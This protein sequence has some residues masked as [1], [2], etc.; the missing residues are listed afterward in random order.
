MSGLFTSK[1]V[2]NYRFKNRIIM[3]PMASEKATPT[4]EVTDKTINYYYERAKEGL[5]GVIVEH[6]F[7][8]EAGRFSK[9]Q[10]SIAEDSMIDGLSSLASAIK[11]TGTVAIIQLSHAGCEAYHRCKPF[12]P[13]GIS[14]PGKEE[15]NSK[16][17]SIGEISEI[18]T[19]FIKAAE[20]AMKAGFDG[21]E[22]H[23]AH[24]YLLNQFNSPL[25]NHRQDKY[26]G[27]RENRARLSF[28]I[29][30][31]I[32]EVVQDKLLLY[33]LGAVDQFEK[34]LTT[35]DAIWI[36]KELVR[37]GV[38]II[39]ISGGLGGYR[40]SKNTEGYFVTVAKEIN[41]NLTKPVIVAGGITSPEYANKVVEE[42]KIDFVGIGRA[43]LSRPDWPLSA[44]KELT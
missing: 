3:P 18:K 7:I 20:R 5:G 28:E 33:R 10:L 39:D 30:Q 40:G 12:S 24:G 11:S 27:S 41:Q 6:A 13:S 43:I 37:L 2:R 36:A 42:E 38:D 26:G 32:R 22:I 9:R 44:K 23:G 1:K 16:K 17:L 8:S 35:P 34:G 31:D 19:D 29:A 4:G 14:I 25:T 21:V 15:I